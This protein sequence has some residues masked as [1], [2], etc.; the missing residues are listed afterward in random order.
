MILVFPMILYL[1]MIVDCLIKI[2][3]R[4]NSK[5]WLY[6]I[7]LIKIFQYCKSSKLHPLTQLQRLHAWLLPRGAELVED[8]VAPLALAVRHH[9]RALQEVRAEGCP[10]DEVGRAEVNLEV[11]AK[12]AAVV[13]AYCPG[14]AQGLEGTGHESVHH[15]NV[16]LDSSRSA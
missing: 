11:L 9:S 16:M 1:K 2:W 5:K 3:H 15:H 4:F 14:V 13:V 8:V 12:P 10:G 7:F 6:I